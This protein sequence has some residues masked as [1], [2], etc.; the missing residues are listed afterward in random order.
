M[1]YLAPLA[2]AFALCVGFVSGTVYESRQS[3][4]AAL[5]AAEAAR[6]LDMARQVLQAQRDRLAKENED[7]A[8]AEPP[9]HPSCLPANRLRRLN[10]IR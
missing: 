4:Q 8:R 10:K 6:K 5:D 1:T 7:L 3:T 2:L 9:S